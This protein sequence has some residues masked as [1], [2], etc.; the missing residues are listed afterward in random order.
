MLYE[1]LERTLVYSYRLRIDLFSFSGEEID[2]C[3]NLERKYRAN[4]QFLSH[5]R[6]SE[7]VEEGI[8]GRRLVDRV[9]FN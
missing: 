3:I 8:E 7:G 1:W 9:L 5:D 6:E 4:W 2:V